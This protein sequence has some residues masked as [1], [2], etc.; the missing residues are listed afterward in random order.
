MTDT[1]IRASGLVKEFEVYD[2]PMDL[3]IEVLLRRPKHRKFRALDGVSFDVRRGEV[4][5]II[6]SNGAG[7]STLLK[8]ITGVLDASDGTV[9]IAGRVTAILELGLGF[10]PEFSGR[11][12]IHL[13]GL[14][15]GMTREEVEQKLDSIIAFSGL[16]EFI[17]RP[18]KTYSSGMHSRLAF[19]IATAVD[20]DILIIDEALAAGDAGF[21]QKCFRRIRELCAGGRTVLLV[22]HGTGTLAQLCNRVMW[23]EHGRVRAIGPAITVIQAYDLAQHQS[24][25]PD[26]SWI[27]RVEDDLTNAAPAAP[28]GVPEP[29]AA[30][31][32][33]RPVAATP[34]ALFAS[35]DG[36][37]QVF[38]RGPVL[39]ESVEMFGAAGWRTD[40]LTLLQP[41]TLEIRYRVEGPLP[42]RSL[43]VAL[44]INGKADLAPVAQFFTQN[45]R[46][47]ETRETYDAAPDRAMP[48]R[49]G[50][51]R[52][53]FDSMPLR[54]GEYMLSLGLLPNEPA[55]WEFYEYRHF[56]YTFSVDDVGMDVGAPV[57]LSPVL[58]HQAEDDSAAPA[59]HPP[60]TPLQVR[61][62]APTDAH[63]PP[64]PRAGLPTLRGE[65]EQVCI[66]EG[67]YPGRW[68]RHERCP[69]CDGGPLVKAFAKYGFDHA[70]C[71]TCGF[72]C[73]DPYPPE[74]IMARLYAGEYYT[75]IR[76]L[77][78]LPLLE[79]R[80]EGTP[81]SAPREVLEGIV[82]RTA[83][84]RSGA[85]LDVG[86][87]LGA[88]AQLV[89][90]LRPGWR[91]KLNESNP[92][93][94][95]VARERL[96]L[97]VVTGDLDALLRQDER[98]DVIS[99]VAV[100]EH[101]PH[102]AAF[103]S[104]YARLL[105]PHG[106]LVTVVPQFTPLNGFVSRSSSPNA[107]PPYHV[108]LFNE[109]TLRRMLTRLPGL[110]LVGIEQAG[111]AAFDLT[112]H[113]QTGDHWD[114]EFPTP[115]SPEP[116]SIRIHE[117]EE[118]Q[119]RALEALDSI[120]D[121]LGEYF[122][123]HDGRLYLIAY[124]RAT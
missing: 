72:I 67:G 110:E 8:I 65:I 31:H 76:E 116:R 68:P 22:S 61:L 57:L 111:P 124:C 89:R 13:S 109:V 1:A 30:P 3:A 9:D 35:R 115:E 2:K 15:Y 86:G 56:Y 37:R 123:D 48:A 105:R 11:E 80:G 77:L 10:N 45:I 121:R 38:R 40:R 81:F 117:Y 122:A 95:R 64:A 74:E 66:V 46:P 5:G 94:V 12:N 69:A 7:K 84:A 25:D 51:L 102:P 79:A 92:F 118:D 47:T 50:V 19:S 33:P 108:S 29:D 62:P 53:A 27:E 103:L 14:L 101:I 78:E 42:R 16:G 58:T 120:K 54:K 104:G 71:G 112:Q 87:G 4:L 32:E 24:A 98:F 49:R 106:W 21:V 23:L 63:A 70:R 34:A 93:S 52:L 114:V 6:G 82:A 26:G 18:V 107:V 73:V 39:I 113:V 59:A 88:F 85:W 36:D 75:R 44:A 60:P 91:V 20:P 90:Q 97:D 41:F 55:S 99:S 28:E 43:G 119:R 17:E 96:G 100:A 83:A